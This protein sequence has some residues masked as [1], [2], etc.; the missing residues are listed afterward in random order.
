MAYN[1]SNTYKQ[2]IYSQEDTNDLKIWF[3][4][5][6]L[7][8][9][10]V[11]CE[12]LTR[13]ARILPDDGSKRFSIDN[14]ISTSIE[15][16]LHNVNMQD[17]QDQVKISIG[18][19]VS[20]NTYEYVPL[21]VFNIQEEPI[22]DNGKITLKLRDNR[23]KFDFNYNA[24]PL[25]ETL[26]GAATKKQI[27][28]NICSQAGVTNTITTFNG[29]SDLVGIYDNTI[30]AS[31]YVSYLMEQAGLIAVIDRLGQLKA[32]DLSSL[33]TWQIPVS[34]LEKGFKI[35]DSYQINRV[36]YESGIIKYETS[37]DETLDT[38]Y[39]NSANPYIT[40]N[41]QVTYI[42]NKLK[43][44]VIDSVETKRV[45]GNPAIDPYDLIEVYDDYNN[46]TTLF[47][48][49]ANTTYEFNGKHTDTFD[50]QIG[51]EQ[52]KENVTISGEPNFRKYAKTNID[53]LNAEVNI[54][55]GKVVDIS[56]TISGFMTI[57]L[58]NAHKGILHRL[59]IYGE[60]SNLFPKNNLY[61]NNSMYPMG[62]YLIVDEER[63]ELPIDRL[64]Y[65]SAD[66]CDKF[67]YED[68]KCWIERRNGTIENKPDMIIEIDTSSTLE[69]GSLNE[70]LFLKCTYLLENEY[71]STFANQVTVESDIN[72]L[73]D[74]IEAKVSQVAD[75]NGNVTSASIILAVNNDESIAEINANKINLN[76]AVTA[77]ENFKI[78]EDGSMEAKN[79]N[80]NGNVILLD[81]GIENDDEHKFGIKKNNNSLYAYSDG[82]YFTYPSGNYAKTFRVDMRETPY[83]PFMLTLEDPSRSKTTTID[84]TGIITPAVYAE[85]L[86]V[87][88]SKNRV[89]EVNGKKLLMNAYE[90]PAPYFGDIGSNQTDNNGYCKIYIDKLFKETIEDDDY[91]VF[92]QECGEGNLYV[93]KSKEYFEVMGTKNLNFDWEIKAIQKGYKQT[94]LKELK[95]MK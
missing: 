62:I 40:S 42:Y 16:I 61:P 26:G 70:T 39:L 79:G 74:S 71:T 46:N 35:G 23:V 58:E 44:F 85:E 6:E 36:V 34:V 1:V 48:T 45:L 8:N 77:N 75:S 24:Q 67:I 93:K 63:Y 56:N 78:L 54:I 15:L 66:D 7:A 43:D 68:G 94:R 37:N 38:L 72:V 4:D 33:T 82:L 20:S 22:N 53:N 18:T 31:T 28:D 84:P 52:R 13:I 32:I 73:S 88:G 47:T 57:T 11:Y 3:N 27:L 10:G 83:W 55:A 81:N 86:Y 69:I 2:V 14:F 65:V 9:A 60:Y 5:V 17:I 89:V 21:G 90:T 91:K 41:S 12:K 92:I 87:S 64:E 59:E 30:K 95:E 29:A 49:L 19:L 76:G 25:L 50:T 51:L 80:F